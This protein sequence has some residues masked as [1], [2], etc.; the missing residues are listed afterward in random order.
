MH[1]MNLKHLFSGGLY[2]FKNMRCW[3]FY[4]IHDSNCSIVIDWVKIGCFAMLI[5]GSVVGSEIVRGTMSSGL[6]GSTGGLA[7]H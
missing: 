3:V 4:N 2:L 5:S 1:G 6:A 7:L